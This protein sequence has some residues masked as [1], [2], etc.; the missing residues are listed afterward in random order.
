[1]KVTH[2]F[3][4]PKIDLC[5]DPKGLMNYIEKKLQVGLVCLY[6]DKAYE[7]IIFLKSH[8]IKK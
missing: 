6:C 5:I 8:M 1:M 4:I 2:G 3:F 7:D